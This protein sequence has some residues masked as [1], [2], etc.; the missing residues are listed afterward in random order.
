ME[1][2]ENLVFFLI[3]MELVGFRGTLALL[4]DVAIGLLYIAFSM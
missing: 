1:T 2:V 4:F 3:F